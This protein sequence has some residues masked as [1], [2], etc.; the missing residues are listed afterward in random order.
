MVR[1]TVQIPHQDA[2]LWRKWRHSWRKS[3]SSPSTISLAPLLTTCA[4]VLYVGSQIS[5]PAAGGTGS[6]KGCDNGSHTRYGGKGCQGFAAT[7]AAADG[8]TCDGVTVEGTG[9]VLPV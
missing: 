4:I 3:D 8:R 9:G 5:A 1:A 6:G 2:A 7:E